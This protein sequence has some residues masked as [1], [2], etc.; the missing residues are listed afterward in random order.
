M[1]VDAYYGF[2]NEESNDWNEI[3]NGKFLKIAP[4]WNAISL[5]GPGSQRRGGPAA[6]TVR[7][8]AGSELSAAGLSWFITGPSGPQ[9][10]LE[11]GSWSL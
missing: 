9:G 6:G 10:A 5:H 8:R 1:P 11:L 2:M 4:S 7:R 3:N